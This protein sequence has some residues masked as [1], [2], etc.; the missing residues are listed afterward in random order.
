MKVRCAFSFTDEQLRTVRA[1]HGRGGK[2]TRKE[3]MTFVDRAVAAAFKAAPEPRPVRKRRPKP[4]P[5]PPLAPLT[6]DEERA[7]AVAAR[8]KIAAMYRRSA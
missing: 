3:C 7:A 4:E 2:A 5:P 8:N 6:D 1:A